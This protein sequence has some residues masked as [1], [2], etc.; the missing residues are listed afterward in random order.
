M[1]SLAGSMSDCKLY[2]CLCG[3]QR[4]WCAARI[5]CV[6]I[7]GIFGCGQNLQAVPNIMHSWQ[8]G[9]SKAGM[10]MTGFNLSRSVSC[11]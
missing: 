4:C 2:P 10:F 3:T 5:I 6:P 9:P 8:A 1:A 11:T 7:H